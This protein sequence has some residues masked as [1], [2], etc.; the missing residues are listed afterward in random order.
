MY[1]FRAKDSE[2]KPYPSCLG[3]IYK[4]FTLDNMKKNRIKRECMGFFC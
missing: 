4:D 1:Q 2:I 3:N